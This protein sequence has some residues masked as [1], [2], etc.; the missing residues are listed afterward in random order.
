MNLRRILSQVALVIGA[1]VFS[2]GLQAYAATFS[3]PTVGFPGGNAEAP[4]DTGVNTNI[5]TGNLAVN[6]SG[7]YPNGLV[8]NGDL[9]A[10]YSGTT[11]GH[12]NLLKFVDFRGQTNAVM[13]NVLYSDNLGNPGAS[14]VFK[15]SAFDGTTNLY[16]RMLIDMS[17]NVGIGVASP[18]TKLDVAGAIKIGDTSTCTAGAIRFRNNDFEGCIDGTTWKSLTAGGGGGGCASGSLTR[19]ASGSVK[20]GV[21]IPACVSSVNIVVA[22]AGG[23]G[24]GGGYSSSG[25]GGGG[26]GAGQVSSQTYSIGTGETLDIIVGSPGSVGSGGGQYTPDGGAGGKGGGSSVSSGVVTLAS[27]DGGAGGPAGVS[28]G[29]GSPSTNGGTCAYGT[30]G[31]GG[32]TP[33]GNGYPGTG[34]CS[35]GGG[36]GGGGVY[37]TNGGD[38][39][40][41]TGGLVIISW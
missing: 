35:G 36:G 5:K 10:Q 12:N 19:N 25:N 41:G 28:S 14:L 8:V 11:G 38:G 2:I 16:E 23:G 3:Q 7:T 30:G 6:T 27:A 32:G 31:P 21:E 17:G 29:S 15:T 24:A 26:G 9:V 18:T 20:Q 4:L 34:N 13:G 37:T 22:G 1:L 40:S 39:A 33:A